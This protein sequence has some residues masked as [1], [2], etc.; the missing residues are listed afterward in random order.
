MTDNLHKILMKTGWVLFF[1]FLFLNLINLG[2]TIKN[3]V[4]IRTLPFDIENGKAVNFKDSTLVK[5]FHNKMITAIDTLIVEELEKQTSED[6]VN[7]GRN[8]NFIFADQ[9]ESPAILEIDDI[10]EKI[11]EVIGNKKEVEITYADSIS[12]QTI[13]IQ[14][15]PD[16]RYSELINIGFNA[17]FLL[18]IFFNSFLLLKYSQSKENILIVLF[19]LLLSSP[20]NLPGFD[21]S[22]LISNISSGFLGILFYHFIVQKVN[23]EKKVIKIYLLTVLLI[24][25]TC[26][27]GLIIKTNLGVLLY[28]W[29]VVWIFIGFIILWKAYKKTG[30][31]TMK[32]LLNAFR[33]IFI[34]L[35]SIIAI[36]LLAAIL[37]LYFGVNGSVQFG[38]HN[39]QTGVIVVLLLIS[40]LGFFI[41]IL[42]F[43]G[44]FTWGL[45]TGTTL[46]IKIRS[47]MIYSIIGVFFIAFFG[48]IDYSLGEL[49]QSLFGRFVGSEFIAGIPA[50]IGL[51][52]F[53]NPVRNR[54]EKFVDNKLNT[55]DLDFLEKTETFTDALTGESVIEGF[56]EYICENLIQRLPITKVALVSYDK[57]MKSYKYNEIRGSDIEEN[58]KVED[59]HLYL[60]ENRMIRNYGP[61]NEN[62]QE[63][64]SFALIIPIIHDLEHKWFLTLGKKNDGTTYSKKDEEALTKLA[65]KIKLSLKF[66]LAY[67]NI[68]KNKF[69]ET[70]QEKEKRIENL[71]QQIKELEDKLV[72]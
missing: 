35:V 12:T 47:T 4:F 22:P 62:Q 34:S 8:I 24:L 40:L 61:L 43:F 27:L 11:H 29:S 46:D 48:L 68:V 58:S 71:K 7:Q 42:W 33:G 52:A 59:I 66:I 1:T 53:F 32:R 30:S 69:N 36:I 60:L 20:D 25:I 63:I 37:K 65:N 19:L 17:L 3:D 55:S 10:N 9:D 67:D 38:I 18:F 2:I 14:T 21:I 39:I 13:T 70:L 44:S 28:V 5:T 57:E 6:T 31:I 51:L 26:F 50:T 23:P 45:L 64:A 15:I 72:E 56:E 41:G 54:V 49:L 16:K